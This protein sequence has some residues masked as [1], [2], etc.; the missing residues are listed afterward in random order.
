V[1]HPDVRCLSE[2]AKRVTEHG[3]LWAIANRDPNKDE[4]WW[5]IV[6]E[7]EEHFSWDR[8]LVGD[9]VTAKVYRGS[10]EFGSINGFGGG[11]HR[12]IALAVAV[13]SGKTPYRPF[14]ILL[15]CP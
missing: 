2:I 6:K 1:L 15:Y 3:Y 7:I 13:L 8:L 11:C 14:E 4:R 10:L 9:P 12:S 5:L